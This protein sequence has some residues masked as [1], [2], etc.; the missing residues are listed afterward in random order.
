M[1]HDPTSRPARDRI[2]VN[3]LHVDTF[4]GL[5]D[6]EREARQQVRFDVDIET[7]DGYAEIVR[8]TGEYV[9]YAE[10]VDYIEKRVDEGDHV[11][12]VESWAEDVATHTLANPLVESVRV[13]VQKTQIFDAADG[14]G[15]TIERRRPREQS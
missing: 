4:I 9:S 7:V 1:H 6:F 13:T 3:G 10:V 14:V 15:I 2:L 11:P 8:S 5:H 12:F